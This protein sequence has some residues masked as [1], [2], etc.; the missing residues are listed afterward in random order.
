MSGKKDVTGANLASSM[1]PRITRLMAKTK[2]PVGPKPLEVEVVAVRR[3][4]ADEMNPDKSSFLGRKGNDVPGTSSQTLTRPES[5]MSLADRV[6]KHLSTPLGSVAS[7]LSPDPAAQQSANKLGDDGSVEVIQSQMTI[8][9]S[10]MNVDP[11]E[12]EVAPG[13]LAPIADLPNVGALD[14]AGFQTGGT[15][16]K[17]MYDNI[18]LAL[19][20]QEVAKAAANRRVSQNAAQFPVRDLL[21]SSQYPNSILST[22]Q[23]NQI[24]LQHVDRRAS[25][26]VARA[27]VPHRM[28][29][30]VRPPPLGE[31]VAGYVPVPGPAFTTTTPLQMDASGKVG[32]E[33]VYLKD[34]VLTSV[35]ASSERNQDIITRSCEWLAG[36]QIQVEDDGDSVSIF[37]S[38]SLP[39]AA[40]IP[41][42]AISVTTFPRRCRVRDPVR[43]TTMDWE[44][45][46]EVAR[47]PEVAR[48]MFMVGGN[49]ESKSIVSQMRAKIDCSN[50]MANRLCTRLYES[51][52]QYGLEGFFFVLF[53]LADYKFVLE[54]NAVEVAI[55]PAPEGAITTINLAAEGDAL[56]LALQ[57]AEDAIATN[58]ICFNRIHLTRVH[59]NVLRAATLGPVTFQGDNL[60][61]YVGHH[62][63]TRLIRFAIYDVGVIAAVPVE[64]PTSEQI[65]AAAFHFAR[66]LHAEQ[67]LVRG[68]VRAQT[69]VNGQI[70][71]DEQFRDMFFMSTLE[72]E[73]LS[74]PRPQGRNFMWDFLCDR[75]ELLDPIAGYEVEYNTLAT[76]R[77]S[78]SRCPGAVVAALVSLS[79]S[80]YFNYFNIGGT[81]LNRWAAR[82]DTVVARFLDVA[83]MS[84][85]RNT[86]PIFQ[87]MA[88]NLAACTGFVVSPSCFR[89]FAWCAGFNARDIELAD[90]WN[91]AWARHIPYIVH[92]ISMAWI[93]SAWHT[94]WGYSGPNPGIHIGAEL[95]STLPDGMRMV[96]VHMGDDSYAR[97]AQSSTPFTYIIYGA[98]FLNIWRQMSRVDFAGRISFVT[99]TRAQSGAIAYGNQFV[100]DDE[101][102]PAYDDASFSIVPGTLRTYIWESGQVLGPTLRSAHWPAM[103]YNL[104]MALG[105][106][107]EVWAGFPVRRDVRC[108]TVRRDDVDF[109]VA[110]GMTAG[111]QAMAAA[112][113]SAPENMEN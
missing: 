113:P 58:R 26:A 80:T 52:S 78:T 65:F 23:R 16:T 105:D 69:V 2:T 90:G 96:A 91:S 85:D 50:G 111:D 61:G 54:H 33:S 67:C 9:G 5:Q 106:K 36:N 10:L 28:V 1:S 73:V 15:I 42:Q 7:V 108:S 59:W 45:P 24:G 62:L 112:Q 99:I 79:I 83:L 43:G 46:I 55:Q 103:Y 31:P 19:H 4:S 34:A 13:P 32:R 98:H 102:Q 109:A 76:L 11:L 88:A 72:L 12:E 93:L 18:M 41:P 6:L 89:S 53:V 27:N 104:M 63:A 29:N 74:M 51:T 21:A 87:C 95:F 14:L 101:W 84:R 97:V 92:P 35:R 38:V 48:S 25:S 60:N 81:E 3:S 20:N 37:D 49:P 70:R 22:S 94:V 57:A 39:A 71:E 30:A 75:F 64:V 107:R 82:T 100:E 66:L 68:W 8:N 110:M 44:T 47:L 56:E 40:G 77:Q 86:A 17:A